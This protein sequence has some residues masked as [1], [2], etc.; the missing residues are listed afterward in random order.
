M[1]DPWKHMIVIRLIALAPTARWFVFEDADRF[2]LVEAMA[3]A[4]KDRIMAYCL[5]D[6]RLDVIA[7]GPEKKLRACMAR[8]FA[9]YA[10]RRSERLAIGE[11]AAPARVNGIRILEANSLV[12][13]INDVHALPVVYGY[14]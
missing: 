5:L 14:V 2:D 1:K 4:F 7:E 8:T 10:E 6:D 12:I 11:P 13:A 9:L 3:E